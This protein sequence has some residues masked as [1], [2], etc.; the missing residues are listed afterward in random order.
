VHFLGRFDTTNAAG[1]RFAYPG[2]GISAT[3]TGTGISI[4]LTD[5]GAN[6]FD[7][8]IDGAPPKLLKTSGSQTPSL[9]SGLAPGTHTVLLVRRTEAFQG[10][11]Q[12]KGFTVTGGA[13]IPTPFPFKRVIEFIGDSITCGYGNV[14]AMPCSFSADTENANLAWGAVAARA[15]DAM[16]VLVAYSGKGVYRN[17]GGSMTNL[18]PQVWLRT[19]ADDASSTWDFSRIT[20]DVVVVN[21]GTNDYSGGDP[22]AAFTTAYTAF[23]KQIRAKY[24]SANIVCTTG[25]MQ[26]SA[27]YQARVA[28]A[29]SAAQDAKVSALDLGLQNCSSEVCGCDYHPN[30]STHAKMAATLVARLKTLQGW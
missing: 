18:M 5:Q 2:S 21:L 26:D 7:V 22:G 11:V 12:F 6:Q 1:P 20:P 14:G 8:S 17:N 30:T 24:P 9:A 16:P 4:S 3:F 15:L 10:I 29:I 25:T 13:L 23:L 19:F 28:A 27:G